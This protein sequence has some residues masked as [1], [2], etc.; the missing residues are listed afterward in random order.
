MTKPISAKK[1]SPEFEAAFSFVREIVLYVKDDKTKAR[2]DI[3]FKP[4]MPQFNDAVEL[5]KTHTKVVDV[6]K[7]TLFKYAQL[8]TGLYALFKFAEEAMPGKSLLDGSI[9]AE[10]VEKIRAL[11]KELRADK[12]VAKV[13]K[14]PAKPKSDLK[15]RRDLI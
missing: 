10:P 2:T 6:E 1:G 11:A 9:Y 12:A 8:Y 15:T 5:I 7:A 14:I 3:R 13:T 4:G